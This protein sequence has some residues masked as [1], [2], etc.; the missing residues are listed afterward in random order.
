MRV[1]GLEKEKVLDFVAYCKKHRNEID[2]SYLYDSDLLE[3]EIRDENPTYLAIN[4]QDEIIGVASLVMD[5]YHNRGKRA[6]FRIFHCKT[7]DIQCYQQLL[8]A[9][10]KH[11]AGLDKVFLFIPVVNSKL[12]EM[13]EGLKFSVERYAFLLVREDLDVPEIH[14][15][16][17]YELRTFRPRQDENNW[18]TVRNIA[19]STLKG[20]E[21]PLT[22]EGVKKLLTYDDYLEGGMMVLF[23]QEKPV[24]VIRGA[25]DE[26]DGAPIMNI[27]PVAILPEYQG[28]GLGRSLLRAS[29]RFAKEKGYKRTILSVNGEND[30]AQ[31]LYIQEGF[32]QVEAVVCYQYFLR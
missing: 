28:R 3:F 11:T 24:G 5:D 20:S 7:Q 6:R 22:T 2:D 23:Y 17:G 19:F 21:T 26:Y 30:R 13:V 29:L 27:G 15:P 4:Q 1:E 14:F 16:E 10:L 18:L 8:E 9:V 25:H 32:K 12:I 31:A